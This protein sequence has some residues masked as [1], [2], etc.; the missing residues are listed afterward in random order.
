MITSIYLRNFKAFGSELQE[1]KCKPLT[2]IFGE[3]SSGKSTILKALIALKQT[4]EDY[5]TN[6]V[7]SYQGRLVD[8]G[9]FK[10]FVFGHDVRK[11]VEIG[12]KWI[13]D[14][15]SI[16]EDPFDFFEEFDEKIP[17]TKSNYC[18]KL[19]YIGRTVSKKNLVLLDRAEWSCDFLEDYGDKPIRFISRLRSS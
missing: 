12:V 8:I 19:Q 17:I 1:I 10:E 6:N 16:R 14:S 18:T 3:N 7:L 2:L 11:K 5:D 15:F 9:P 13:A 4:I